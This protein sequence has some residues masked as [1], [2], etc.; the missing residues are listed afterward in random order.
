MG[1]TASNLDTSA[2]IVSVTVIFLPLILECSFCKFCKNSIA[3][4]SLGFYSHVKYATHLAL[5][6]ISLEVSEI[7]SI[8][9]SL[10]TVLP[11]ILPEFWTLLA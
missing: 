4:A 1:L 2:I 10:R 7:A 5:T 9:G 6:K 3:L 11:P 8:S